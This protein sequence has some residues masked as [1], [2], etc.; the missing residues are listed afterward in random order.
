MIASSA[1]TPRSGSAL[2]PARP[3]QILVISGSVSGMSHT[4]HLAKMVAACL[5]GAGACPTH[6]DLRH[7]PLPIADPDYHDN[8]AAHPD[9]RARNL[10][11]LA[12]AADAFVLASPIYHNS[13]SGV[14][15]NALD[16]LTID[17]FRQKPVGLIS[18]GGYRST[19]AVD[20]LRIVAR[21]LLGVAIPAQ[22]CTAAH[23][24]EP[25]A[26]E[27]GYRIVSSDIVARIDR[28][29]RELVSFAR[30]LRGLRAG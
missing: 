27:Q 14:L 26:A 16:H 13:Y 7:S 24:Y 10:A 21:G 6:W 25:D 20:H 22:I 3:L 23:D 4:R 17:H 9:P 8:P 29:G 2:D 19:Q 15:K 1:V 12:A 11:G 18:H 30:G 5:E 28:F